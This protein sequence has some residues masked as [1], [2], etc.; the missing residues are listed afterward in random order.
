MNV[1][2]KAVLGIAFFLFV[3]IILLLCYADF[4]ESQVWNHIY[5]NLLFQYSINS[6]GLLLGVCLISFVIAFPA[7]Y[8]ISTYQFKGRKFLRW[9]LMLPLTIPSYI[10]A[11]TY[12]GIFDYT[13]MV[14]QML[15]VFSSKTKFAWDIMH[16]VGLSILLAFCL[17]P[18]LY[19]I[20]L[21]F[22]SR[23]SARY[24]EAAQILGLKPL[25]VIGKV[26]LPLSRPAIFA[27]SALIMMELLNDYGAVKYFGFTT[28]TT[29]IFKAWFSMGDSGAGLKLAIVLLIVA[30]LVVMLEKKSRSQMRFTSAKDNTVR[31]L[32]QLKSLQGCFFKIFLWLI[33]LLAFVL[34]LLQLMLWACAEISYFSTDLIGLVF[35]SGMIS[36]IISLLI[37]IIALI[38]VFGGR[39]SQKLWM[40]SVLEIST[41]GYAIPGAVIAVC[42]L[43]PFTNLGIWMNEA[44]ITL[45]F[46]YLFRFLA[47]GY[48]GLEAISEK[49]SSRIDEA[50]RVLGLNYNKI[51]GQILLPVW[52]P[53]IIAAFLMLFIDMI[54]ELPLTLILRPFN[55]DSLATKTFE[56]ASDEL[57]EQAAWPALMIIL[58]G[59]GVSW[60]LN[61]T[62]TK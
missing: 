41:I 16:P 60:I 24:I 8:I 17:Y 18:Y 21:G 44:F 26:V 30:G 47:V 62:I 34:P 15:A 59:A 49:T 20:L 48:N 38:L 52:Q 37:L 39:I 55:Y 35:Q 23:Q 54:K 58:M 3:P 61:K 43:I 31:G 32:M 36:C 57:L 53:A 7:A 11:Y 33:F 6:I 29:G 13:G 4:S 9:G 1:W 51:L 22:F 42:I 5:E 45:G 27:G 12:A 50:A 40:K 14:H 2:E 28:F 10:M 56:L 25:A 19:I 46:G